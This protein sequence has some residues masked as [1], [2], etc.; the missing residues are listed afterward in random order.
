MTPEKPGR[1][2]WP[3]Y[4]VFVRG[5]RRRTA[6]EEG[7]WVREAA[8]AHAAKRAARAEKGAVA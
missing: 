1:Q 6:H 4:E 8:T 2:G 5:E 7:A 3:L